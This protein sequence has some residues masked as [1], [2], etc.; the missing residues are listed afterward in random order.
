MASLSV[1]E[2]TYVPK[3]L[4]TVVLDAVIDPPW[5]GIRSG[6][7]GDLAIVDGNGETH[8]ITNVQAGETIRCG[9]QKVLT[10]GTTIA[11]PTTNLKGLP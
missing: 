8:T 6:A 4:G 5:R 1:K 11:S 9:I 7:T 10:T 3:G 2:G